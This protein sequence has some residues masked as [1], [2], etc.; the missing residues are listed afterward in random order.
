[1]IKGKR[2]LR[3]AEREALMKNNPSPVA[4]HITEFPDL[5]DVLPDLAVEY[6]ELCDAIAPMEARKKELAEQINALLDAVD[7]RKI[8]G[9]GWVAF[10]VAGGEVVTLSPEKLLA[11]GVTIDQIEEAT[12]RKPKKGHI[13]VQEVQG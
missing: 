12:E 3:P 7:Q 5:V 8:R 1:M 6:R 11:L 4:P 2:T 9:D 13:R 10:Y